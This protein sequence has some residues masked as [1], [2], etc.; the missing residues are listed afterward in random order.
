LTTFQIYAALF[1]ATTVYAALLAFLRH[2]W[3]PD[4]T[5][6]EVVIGTALC[7]A[8]PY[9][10]QRLN[11]PLTSEIYEARVWLAFL[12]GGAPVVIWQ[13]GQS[14]SAWR[15]IRRRIRG[16]HVVITRHPTDPA[17]T[18]ADHPG[19]PPETGD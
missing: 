16:D 1:A 10:D 6:L 15:R 18:L 7:L 14:V 9:A 17:E 19:T 13:L 8:A 5:W 11:G 12:I 4:L 2:V 3:E